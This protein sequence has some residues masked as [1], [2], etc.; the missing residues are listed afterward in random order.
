LEDTIT[1][2]N[3]NNDCSQTGLTKMI[4]KLVLLK[5]KNIK[6]LMV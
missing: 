4:D 6:G 2:D 1:I 5:A 3:E